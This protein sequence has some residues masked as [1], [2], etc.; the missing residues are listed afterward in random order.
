MSEGPQEDHS[1]HHHRGAVFWLGSKVPIRSSVDPT[2]HTGGVSVA[3]EGYTVA[4]MSF[5]I[6]MLPEF[7]ILAECAIHVEG[8]LC[9]LMPVAIRKSTIH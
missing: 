7:G 2:R 9:E 8:V 1:R 6:G 5:D 4:G 3:I